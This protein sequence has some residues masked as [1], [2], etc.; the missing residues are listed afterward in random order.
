[1]ITGMRKAKHSKRTFCSAS[2]STKISTGLHQERMQGSGMRSQ[3]EPFSVYICQS[4]EPPTL[5]LQY[6]DLSSQT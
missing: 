4:A 6:P 2:L 5:L 3:T 1:M